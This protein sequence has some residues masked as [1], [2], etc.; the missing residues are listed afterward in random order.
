MGATEIS[1][2]EDEEYA[3]R[4]NMRKRVIEAEIEPVCWI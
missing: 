1:G 4:E 3:I 2:D